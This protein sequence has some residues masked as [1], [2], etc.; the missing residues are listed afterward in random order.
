[1]P[2]PTGSSGPRAFAQLYP[3][4]VHPRPPVKPSPTLPLRFTW[5][6]HLPHLSCPPANLP[7]PDPRGQRDI[8]SLKN[9]R[10]LLPVEGWMGFSLLEG[11]ARRQPPH[12]ECLPLHSL[13]RNGSWGLKGAWA[14]AHL[15]AASNSQGLDP[16]NAVLRPPPPFYCPASEASGN[17]R[18]PVEGEQRARSV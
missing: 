17:H 1:M 8:C 12:R 2:G 16:P 5:P 13:P 11:P 10:D 7:P 18:P 3:C 6:W 14:S 4:R 9:A 15:Q